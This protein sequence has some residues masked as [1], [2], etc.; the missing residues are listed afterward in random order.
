MK[1][2]VPWALLSISCCFSIQKE[3]FQSMENRR[4]GRGRDDKME[5]EEKEEE[6]EELL[7]VLLEPSEHV[8]KQVLALP[9]AP[10][11]RLR[12]NERH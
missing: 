4:R 5:K 10:P 2:D 3:G 7:E 8:A 11:A 12:T 1:G 6:K 9:R